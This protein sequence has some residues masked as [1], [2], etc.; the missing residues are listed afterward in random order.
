MTEAL[1]TSAKTGCLLTVDL[2]EL[3]VNVA[4]NMDG[5]VV[6]TKLEKGI[7]RIVYHKM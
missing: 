5:K 7:M 1:D 4:S 6:C 2:M 3:D